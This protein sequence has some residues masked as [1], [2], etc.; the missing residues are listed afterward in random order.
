MKLKIIALLTVLFLC[1]SQIK[2]SSRQ[3]SLHIDEASKAHLTELIINIADWALTFDIGS[4]AL[5]KGDYS[6]PSIYVSGNLT[7]GLL[8]AY[9]FTNRQQYLNAVYQWCDAFVSQQRTA[10][11]S[12]GNAAGYWLSNGSQGD[13]YFGDTGTAACAL[14]T[15]CRF[16]AGERKDKYLRAL[17]L[18]ARFIIEGCRDEP[19]GQKEA[20]LS[21][22]V[23]TTGRD[24]GAIGCGYYKGHLAI[25]AYTTATATTGGA[26]FSALYGLTNN[27][28][29]GKIAMNAVSWLLKQRRPSGRIPYILEGKVSNKWPYTTMT[30][31]SEAILGVYWRIENEAMRKTIRQEALPCVRWLLDSQNK[32][33]TWGKDK[34]D[35]K[36]SPE[37]INLLVWYYNEA[38]RDKKVLSAIKKFQDNILDPAR[39]YGLEIMESTRTTGF[40]LLGAEELLAPGETFLVKE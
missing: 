2:A 10:V 31:A 25:S 12:K 37:V 5:K 35:K 30:Y 3:V 14:A 17:E 4:G 16:A 18:Y 38:E 6:N 33:G 21:G 29:Y 22:W 13:I 34:A 7:R 20:N 15:A 8:I 27:E 1:P 11:S 28:E 26:F 24:A 23:I 32:D 19:Y 9:A 39:S 40:I 36:R